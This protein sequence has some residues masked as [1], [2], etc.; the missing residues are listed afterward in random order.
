MHCSPN[1]LNFIA[2]QEADALGGE[3]LSKYHSQPRTWKTPETE[4]SSLEDR[5]LRVSAEGSEVSDWEGSKQMADGKGE[6]V[7]SFGLVRL[8]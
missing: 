7:I 2:L 3:T 8:H 4:H 6:A 5:A 1:Q